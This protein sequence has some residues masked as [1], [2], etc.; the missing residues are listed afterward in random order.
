MFTYFIDRCKGYF[1]NFRSDTFFTDQNKNTLVSASRIQ[2]WTDRHF[3]L[4]S[5]DIFNKGLVQ[6]LGDRIQLWTDNQVQPHLLNL[7]KRQIVL[8]KDKTEFVPYFKPT[9]VYKLV[10]SRQV[11]NDDFVSFAWNSFQTDSDKR[12]R[13][14]P[15]INPNIINDYS[16]LTTAEYIQLLKHDFTLIRHVQPDMVTQELGDWVASILNMN[17]LSALLFIKNDVAR[18]NLY[19]SGQMY[20]QW[21]LYRNFLSH[22]I[23]NDRFECIPKFYHKALM[24]DLT[25]ILQDYLLYHPLHKFNFKVSDEI[26][27]T[28]WRLGAKSLQHAIKGMIDQNRFDYLVKSYASSFFEILGEDKFFEFV[29]GNV[30]SL[31]LIWDKDNFLKNQFLKKFDLKTLLETLDI[32]ALTDDDLN[33]LAARDP[34]LFCQNHLSLAKRVPQAIIQAYIDKNISLDKLPSEISIKADDKKIKAQIEQLEN[35]ITKLELYQTTNYIE[36]KKAFSNALKNSTIKGE[37]M[38]AIKK[39]WIKL[40][41]NDEEFLFSLF[42]N[43]IDKERIAQQLKKDPSYLAELMNKYNEIDPH[44]V[45]ELLK[46]EN[47]IILKTADSNSIVTIYDLKEFDFYVAKPN[48]EPDLETIFTK[49]KDLVS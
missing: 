49:L 25:S 29:R 23:M 17:N 33:I 43:Y 27:G 7:T 16:K 34:E 14:Q 48:G 19:C 1:D 45:P 24:N 3:L 38:N 9:K 39:R 2:G 11:T 15:L 40:D 13:L 36:A 46:K 42:V 31:K 47:E 28:L 37:K 30:N 10:V 44:R 26:F 6:S 35:E 5:S 12:L 21:N 4:V 18:D 20:Y 32:T 8:L 41:E 22:E